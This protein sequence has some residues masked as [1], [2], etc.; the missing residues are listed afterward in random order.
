MIDT[1]LE[2]VNEAFLHPLLDKESSMTELL[3]TSNLLNDF[4]IELFLGFSKPIILNRR[5]DGIASHERNGHQA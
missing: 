2:V 4:S 1:G 3:L 5:I